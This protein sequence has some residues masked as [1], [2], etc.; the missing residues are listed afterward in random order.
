MDVQSAVALLDQYREKLN[1]AYP[2]YISHIRFPHYKNLTPDTKVDFTFPVTALVGTNGSG[3]TSVLHAL[4]GT[5]FGYSTGDFWFSTDV[6]PITEGEGSPN[7]FIYGHFHTKAKKVVETRKARVRKVVD[8]IDNPNYWEPTK[9]TSGDGMDPLPKLKPGEKWV[10]LSSDRWN[11]VRRKVIYVNF[12]KELSAFDKY[13]F[14]G[15]DPKLKRLKKKQDVIRRD[16]KI[17]A[18]IIDS[19]DRSIEFNKKNPTLEN[20][21]LNKDELGWVSDILG[22][23]YTSAIF[24][25]HNLFRGSNGLSVVF[26][27]RFG[28]YSEAF[29]GSGEVAVTSLV[30]QV[31]AAPPGSLVLLDEPEVS[32]HPGAQ[33]RLL[34]FL[35]QMSAKTKLQVVFSTHAPQMLANLPNDALKVFLQEETGTFSIL[36]ESHPYAAFRRL[37]VRHG[38]EVQIIVEDR[39]AKGIVEQAMLMMDPVDK[40]RISVDFHPGGASAILSHRI[41]I[42]MNRGEQ[43]YFLLDGDQKRVEEIIDPETIPFADNVKLEALI[44]EQVGIS[45]NFI[46]DGNS[47]GGNQEQRFSV[48]RNYLK[49]LRTHLKFLPSTCPEEMVINLMPEAVP[50]EGIKTS[51]EAKT[52]LRQ[53]AEAALGK[54]IGSADTDNFGIFKMSERRNNSHEMTILVNLLR[55][56]L[57]QPVKA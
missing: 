38:G 36:S 19:G 21:N 49:Y 55:D 20:R 37:G 27:T 32:L 4:Y 22:R 42:M 9:I 25:R 30:V 50:A 31:L 23:E 11:P 45:P 7:R 10:G 12:R 17:L 40:S 24:I 8:K 44:K 15:N 14:F 1:F 5:P 33:E 54:E 3:K 39:L 53:L 16:A 52:I 34:S 6:D 56:I 2:T 48:Q 35:L 28:K 26:S 41:P 29:A 13:F 43:I 46:I 47:S 57:S 51:D 18:Q